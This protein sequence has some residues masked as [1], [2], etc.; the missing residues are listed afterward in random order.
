MRREAAEM[1]RKYLLPL[2]TLLSIFLVSGVYA[3]WLYAGSPLDPAEQQIGLF[4]SEFDYSPEEILPGG[5]NEAPEIGQDHLALIDLILND[6]DYGLNSGSKTVLHD[7]LEDEGVVYSNQKVSGGNLRHLLN[8][9]ANTHNMYY[10]LEKVSD[11]VYYAYTFSIDELSTAGG[12]TVEIVAYRTVL[13]KTDKWNAIT[14]HYGRARTRTLRDLGTSADSNAI[15]YSID[16][17]TWHK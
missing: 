6:Q 3:T 14:S 13:E 16:M 12:S 17:S 1:F 15:P 8:P 10:C 9:T 5:E 7:Y 11:T 2:T 4:L